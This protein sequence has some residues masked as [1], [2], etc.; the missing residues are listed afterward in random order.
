MKESSPSSFRKAA[1]YAAGKAL[2]ELTRAVR[3][4]VEDPN[5]NFVQARDALS[6]GRSILAYTNHISKWD[7]AII[8]RFTDRYLTP[9]GN[10]SGIAGLK[11]YDPSRPESSSTTRNATRLLQDHTGLGVILV[12]QNY[13]RGSYPEPSPAT[14][15]KNVD[16]FNMTAFRRAGRV[17]RS[18]GQVLFIAPEGTRSSTGELQEAEDGLDTLFDLSGGNALAM[19]ITIESIGNREIKPGP[20]N[21]VI[22]RPG[23]PFSLDELD[24][25]QE[26]N[27]NISRKD[28][29]MIR[30]ARLLPPANQG[31]YRR[32]LENPQAYL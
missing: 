9:I 31:H 20:F 10:V 11:H 15:N 22:V 5:G 13:D 26:D 23:E 19:P 32:F 1:D 17:L 6:E 4:S 2:W 30:L 16:Q 14:E 7:P 18:E 21:K 28:L 12:V 29:M 3:V 8:A 27:P 24:Q 25:D